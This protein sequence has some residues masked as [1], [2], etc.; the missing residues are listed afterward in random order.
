MALTNSYLV[1]VKNLKQFMTALLTAQAPDVF[2]QKFLENLEF[3]STND[4]LF[5]GMLKSLGMLDESGAPTDRYYRYLDQTQSTKVL[6]EGIREAY[7]DLFSVHTKAYELTSSEVKNKLR[8]LTQGK[9]SDSVLDKMAM[10]FAQLCSLA[11]W[12]ETTSPKVTPPGT[13]PKS[14]GHQEIHKEMPRIEREDIGQLGG[15]HYNIQIHLPPTRDPAV[16]DAI[17]RSLKEHLG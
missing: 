6:A 7:G 13:P 11:E 12:S 17:F 10:T 4:R 16:Y 9:K 2:T 15:L 14:T 5:I 8:T 3:K 1:T